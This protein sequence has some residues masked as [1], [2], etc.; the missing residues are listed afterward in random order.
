MCASPPFWR[1]EPD[2]RP[3]IGGFADPDDN[4]PLT[5]SGTASSKLKQNS[6]AEVFLLDE[7]ASDLEG[8][9]EERQLRFQTPNATLEPEEIS[10]SSAK[11]KGRLD[12]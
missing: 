4:D 8:T 7:V 11:T 3:P 12:G 9:A 6:R 2:P 1:I 5:G 10:H